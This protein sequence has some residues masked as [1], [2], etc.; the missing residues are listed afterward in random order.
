MPPP[1][2]QVK[3]QTSAQLAYFGQDFPVIVSL[4]VATV[5]RQVE[6]LAGMTCLTHTGIW[7]ALTARGIHQD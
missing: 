4:W 6:D 5:E 2:R 7:K 1:L 3:R